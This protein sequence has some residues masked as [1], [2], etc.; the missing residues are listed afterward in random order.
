MYTQQPPPLIYYYFYAELGQNWHL[1]TTLEGGP[2]HIRG[3]VA[4]KTYRANNKHGKLWTDH[5][6]MDIFCADLIA[7]LI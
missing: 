2:T 1:S 3:G 6:G 4:Q 5:M 7:P